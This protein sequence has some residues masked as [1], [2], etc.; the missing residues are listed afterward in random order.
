MGKKLTPEQERV[1]LQEKQYAGVITGI[2]DN[3][4][5]DAENDNVRLQKGIKDMQEYLV[6]LKDEKE[7]TATMQDIEK[8][9]S[10]IMSNYNRINASTKI[11]NNPFFSKIVFDGMGAENNIFYI[12]LK[13]VYL[14]KI[15]YVLDWRAPISSLYYYSNLG[16]THYDAPMGRIDVDLKLKRQFKVKDGEIIFYIDTDNKIDVL[17]LDQH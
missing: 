7:K 17:T 1:L 11:R 3:I 10:Y 12:G 13:D 2:L 6:T 8:A 14:N 4:I 16:K 15:N 5:S 9:S